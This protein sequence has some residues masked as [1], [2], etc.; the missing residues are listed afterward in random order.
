MPDKG[1]PLKPEMFDKKTQFLK[2]SEFKEWLAK[3]NLTES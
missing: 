1:S 2:L 3:Y